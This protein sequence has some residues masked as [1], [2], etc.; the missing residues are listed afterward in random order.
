M[1]CLFRRFGW[2][3][4]VCL[5]N[6]TI[7]MLVFL[8]GKNYLVI[9]FELRH[10]VRMG[11]LLLFVVVGLGVFIWGRVWVF[12]FCFFLMWHPECDWT[13]K[14]FIPEEHTVPLVVL[15]KGC[16]YLTANL[17]WSCI[18]YLVDK[19]SCPWQIVLDQGSQNDVF[20]WMQFWCELIYW[21][22]C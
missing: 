2:W 15:A 5:K 3:M 4:A 12:L 7:H 16:P 6:T 1:F 20:Q 21:C 13:L 22:T 19:P 10:S 14:H 11:I 17:F 18:F 8:L 9:H